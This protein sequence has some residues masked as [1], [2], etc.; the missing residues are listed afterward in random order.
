MNQ[1]RKD[2]TGKP[3]PTVGKNRPIIIDGIELLA[4]ERRRLPLNGIHGL[5]HWSR[6]CR[7][8]WL[9]APHTGADRD[10]IEAFAL[11]HDVCRAHDNHCTSHGTQA[12]VM[13][14]AKQYRRWFK[15]F[16]ARQMEQLIL[17][18]AGHTN[19]NSPGDATIATC[20]DADRLDI[21]RVGEIVNPAYLFSREAKSMTPFINSR[22]TD[23]KVLEWTK[24]VWPVL[25][26]EASS[27]M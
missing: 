18:V 23:T 1:T 3:A 6:V 27:A 8:G 5:A 24:D 25:Y 21:G 17:A 14:E 16:T 22:G 10:V 19:S 12:A 11:L 4:L 9:L 26:E 2:E 7:T 15:S 20:W 13:L